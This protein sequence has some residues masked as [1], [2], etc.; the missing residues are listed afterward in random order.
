MADSSPRRP[1]A[2]ITGCSTGIGRATALLLDRNGFRVYAGVRKPADAE[3]LQAETSPLF[4][5]LILDVTEPEQ[6]AAT[7]ARLTNDLGGAG[8]LD[9]LVNNA[10]I[11]EGGPIECMAIERLRHQFD[12]NFFGP[13]TLT[14]SVMPLI[15]T[16]RGRIINVASAIA[17]CPM[18]FLG[19]YASSKAAI[20]GMSLSFRRELVWFGIPVSLIQA[21]V[22]STNTWDEIPRTLAKVRQED[23]S[24]RYVALLNDLSDLLWGP[25]R[26]A[27]PAEAVA[28]TILRAAR[29]RRPRAVYRVGPGA[30][31]SM[32][33]N[34]TPEWMVQWGQQWYLRRKRAA[35]KAIPSAKEIASDPA[36][37][38][39]G[40]QTNAVTKPENRACDEHRSPA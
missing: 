9:C 7:A 4:Q 23:R 5:T 3:R 11:A 37:K 6:I 20:C 8:G 25:V 31:M 30:W 2:L 16:A 21:G 40:D 15:H 27:A 39:G 17:D 36:T 29:A 28:R 14:Q 26:N 32:L 38:S 22:I 19:A 12:V 33:A 18:P 1:S 10:G 35:A 24:G 13:I 34:Q